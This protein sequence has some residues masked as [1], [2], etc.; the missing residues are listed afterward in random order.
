[1]LRVVIRVACKDVAVA[2]QESAPDKQSD[3]L[4]AHGVHDPLDIGGRRWGH[5]VKL[6]SGRREHAVS[7]SE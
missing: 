7:N 3:D 6:G 4:V 1:M 5:S 2:V